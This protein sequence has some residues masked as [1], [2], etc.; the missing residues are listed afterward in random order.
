MKKADP[1]SPIV[2]GTEKKKTQIGR[3]VSGLV[4]EKISILPLFQCDPDLFRAAKS[5]AMALTW[6]D[7]RRHSTWRIPK[8]TFHK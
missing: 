1:W 4:K 8:M 2:V 5:E 6:G 7:G 3:A